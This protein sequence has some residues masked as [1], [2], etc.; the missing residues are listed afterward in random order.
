MSPIKLIAIDQDGTLLDDNSSVSERNV[1]AVQSAVSHGIQVIIATGKTYMSAVPVMEKLGIQ[2]PG[3]FT[4]GLVI[5]NADGSVRYERALDRETAVQ[6]I[7]F[8]EE[9]NLPQCAYCGPRILTPRQGKYPRLLHEKYQEPPLLEV[10]PLLNMID[11]I[12]INKLL[13]S[14]EQNNGETRRRLAEL[15]GD[16]ATVTQAVPEF[17]EVLPPGASKG[18]GVKL[19]LDDL[20]IAPHEMLAIGDGE[21]DVEMLQMAGIAVAMGNGRTAVKTIADFV[22]ADNNHS[23]VAEAI[24]KFAL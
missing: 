6:L 16:K 5:C 4:Q 12:R 3:V 11:D 17:I 23:G 14:D 15:V 22:T 19:L 13:L 2:A 24:E 9:H 21:N 18:R 8:S 7:Q 1:Q 20:G 10:G